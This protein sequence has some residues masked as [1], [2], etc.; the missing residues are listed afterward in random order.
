METAV[1][2]LQTVVGSDLKPNDIEVAYVSADK[3]E[4]RFQI[5]SPEQIDRHLTAISERD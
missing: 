3:D 5:L 2:A 1:I 4:Q